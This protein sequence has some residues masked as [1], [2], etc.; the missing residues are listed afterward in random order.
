M[1]I[2]VFVARS[3]RAYKYL[4]TDIFMGQSYNANRHRV[5]SACVSEEL[6]LVRLVDVL[7]SLVFYRPP[8][9][10]NIAGDFRVRV[11]G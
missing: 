7:T 5:H 1:L 6:S 8:A 3:G 2:T 9:R 11:V 10:I 4:V